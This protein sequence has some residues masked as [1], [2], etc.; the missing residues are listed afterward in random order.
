MLMSIIDGNKNEIKR[1]LIEA[2]EYGLLGS[3]GD[4]RRKRT[5]NYFKI[6]FVEKFGLEPDFSLVKEIVYK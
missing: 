5:R 3:N 2:E 4:K 1:M 6:L